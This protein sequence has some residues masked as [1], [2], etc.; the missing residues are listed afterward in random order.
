MNRQDWGAESSV[1]RW[2]TRAVV[3]TCMMLSRQSSV[4]KAK[5]WLSTRCRLHP[6]ALQAASVSPVG[7]LRPWGAQDWEWPGRE[8]VKCMVSCPELHALGCLWPHRDFG[9]TRIAQLL[10]QWGWLCGN[11]FDSERRWEISV[12]TVSRL[13][14]LHMNNPHPSPGAG[15]WRCA[16]VLPTT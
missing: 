7:N 9:G 2:P 12:R 3:E 6:H 11:V 5:A 14:D 4:G 8:G 1:R 13:R 10:T 15:L 16:T